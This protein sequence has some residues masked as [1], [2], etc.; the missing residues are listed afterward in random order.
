MHSSVL[1]SVKRKVAAATCL[2]LAACVGATAY[3]QTQGTANAA[4]DTVVSVDFGTVVGKVP[5]N[6]FGVTFST[7]GVEGGPV[8]KSPEDIAALRDLKVGAIR[9]HLKPDGKGGVVSGAGGGVTDVTGHEWLAAIESI[10]AE[11]TVIVN[12]DTSDALDVL[13]YLNRQGHQVKR[14]IIGNEMDENSKSKMSAAEY[15]AAFR[16]IAAAM[17]QVTPDLR[18]GGPAPAYF[19]EDLLRVFVQ[20]AVHEAPP[21]ER[22]SFVDY[23]AYG[24]GNNE[25]ATIASSVRYVQQLDRLRT[26]IGAADVGLQVGEFNMNWGDESQNNTHFASV[27]VANALGSIVTRGATAMLYADKNNAMGVLGPKG[28]PKAS[29]VGLEMFTGNPLG[30]RHFGRDVV[31]ASSNN[32]DVFVYASNNDPNIVIVN[33][34]VQGKSRVDIRG[35]LRGSIDVWQSA[36]PQGQVNSPTKTGTRNIDGS[37]LTLDLPALSITTLVVNGLVIGGGDGKPLPS[38]TPTTSSTATPVPGPVPSGSATPTAPASPS[39]SGTP[40]GP[41]TTPGATPGTP[42]GGPGA[43]TVPGQPPAP[44][45]TPPGGGPVP[46]PTTSSAPPRA[47]LPGAGD[48]GWR[49]YGSAAKSGDGVVLTRSDQRFA[50]GSLAYDTAVPTAAL[51]ASFDVVVGGG[52]GGDGVTLALLDP[53]SGSR[54]GEIGGGLGYSGLSGPAVVFDTFDNTAHRP[55][56]RVGVATAGQGSTLQ[57]AASTTAVPP[58]RS[59]RHVDVTVSAGTVTVRVDGALVLSTRIALPDRAVV[60][61][62][63]ATGDTSD[64]HTVRNIR[65][66]HGG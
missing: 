33:T 65:I 32:P 45:V 30:L 28:T 21:A 40:G 44:P 6:R 1:S 35:A 61:F 3:L 13:N 26:L 47:Q 34:G 54:V 57:Y 53:A 22:A 51:Q 27:W 52:N 59:T 14:F 64:T 17:R 49:P 7:F 23:H 37:G 4:P 50:A 62:T 66:S 43:P 31:P 5:A 11:P 19:D 39:A 38:A 10:G 29:H 56:D 42:S 60:A 12:T 55:G 18:I 58:L 9:V 25:N 48:A 63:A 2:A 41:G 16:R 36:G 20:G 24:A 46:G 15:T 8:A